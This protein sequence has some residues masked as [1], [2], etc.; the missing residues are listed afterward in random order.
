MRPHPRR[1]GGGGRAPR[2]R[3]PSPGLRATDYLLSPDLSGKLEMIW[4]EAEPGGG[5][6]DQPYVHAGDEEC[7]VV[8]KGRME[9][10]VGG[11]RYLLHAGDAITFSSR[12]PHK[13]QN[14]GRGRL[15]A[16]WT[17]TPP[18][19]QGALAPGGGPL[20]HGGR[21]ARASA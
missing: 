4:A 6:G 19:Y 7:V 2:A 14:V 11:E 10:W 16:L 3:L 8:I 17:I 13:W 18:A 15:E 1:G 12:V 20:N 5:S 21:P 9:I